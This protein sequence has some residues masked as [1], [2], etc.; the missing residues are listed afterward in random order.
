M[1]LQSMTNLPILICKMPEKV[2]VMLGG[3]PRF[4]LGES[5]TYGSANFYHCFISLKHYGVKLGGYWE[6]SF[7][8]SRIPG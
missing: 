3:H 5:G 2:A 6:F 7:R 4:F 1:D 8:S